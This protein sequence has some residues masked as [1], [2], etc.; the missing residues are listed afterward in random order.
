MTRQEV[1]SK[2]PHLEILKCS[3]LAVQSRNNQE[4]HR[5]VR[6]EGPAHLPTQNLERR[7]D[8][9]WHAGS[10]FVGRLDALGGLI[11]VKVWVI[12][13]LTNTDFERLLFEICLLLWLYSNLR[14]NFN[15]R[16]YSYRMFWGG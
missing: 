8:S 10:F 2:A 9:L 15:L 3:T 5:V 13:H 1:N 16:L 14:L 4:L 7:L 6:V 11:C 12:V